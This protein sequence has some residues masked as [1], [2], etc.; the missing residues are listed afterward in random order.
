MITKNILVVSVIFFGLLVVD[1]LAYQGRLIPKPDSEFTFTEPES[2][3]RLLDVY[4][5]H[6]SNHTIVLKGNSELGYYYATLF[7]G[8]P[9]QKETLIVDT[10]SGI[11]V[12]PCRST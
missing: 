4:S 3:R 7:F 8:F 5:P 2:R 6:Y 1:I 11:T 12:I 9:P 10:G